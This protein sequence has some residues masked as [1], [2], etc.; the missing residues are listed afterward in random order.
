LSLYY[1]LMPGLSVMVR[2]LTAGKALAIALLLILGAAAATP[3]ALSKGGSKGGGGEA[4]FKAEVEVK[5][6]EGAVEVKVKVRGAP[7]GTYD[8]ILHEGKNSTKIG[9]LTVN[10]NG[11]GEAKF[12]I[13][14]EAGQHTVSVEVKNGSQTLLTTGDMVVNVDEPKEDEEDE[15]E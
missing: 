10:S 3:L 12:T 11:R 15:D 13:E 7:P 8:I 2:V 4:S 5:D 14:M 1:H 6:E 9:E